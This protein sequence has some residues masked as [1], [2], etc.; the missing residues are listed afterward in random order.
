MPSGRMQFGEHARQTGR[1]IER[2]LRLST[3]HLG[4]RALFLLIN[5]LVAAVVMAL[6]FLSLIHI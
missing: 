5:L 4:R 1:T 2:L 3:R 6:P